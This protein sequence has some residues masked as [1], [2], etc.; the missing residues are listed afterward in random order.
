LGSHYKAHIYSNHIYKVYLYW[1]IPGPGESDQ[2]I[3]QHLAPTRRKY[4]YI[5]IDYSI[6]LIYYTNDDY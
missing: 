6:T 4:Q 5:I 3:R 2:S 1:K